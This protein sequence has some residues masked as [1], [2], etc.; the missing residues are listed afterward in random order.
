MPLNKMAQ[1]DARMLSTEKTNRYVGGM[2]DPAH[3]VSMSA[4]VATGGAIGETRIH[5]FSN[6]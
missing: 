5:K 2:A 1:I 3:T 4:G 6:D